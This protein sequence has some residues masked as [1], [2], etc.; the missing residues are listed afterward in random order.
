MYKT[1][2]KLIFNNYTDKLEYIQILTIRDPH[3]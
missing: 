2:I 1:F 3:S